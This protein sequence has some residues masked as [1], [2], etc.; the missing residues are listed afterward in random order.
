MSNPRPAEPSEFVP[1]DY[2][3][4]VESGELFTKGAPLEVDLGTGDGSFLLQ[5]AARHPERNFL[6]VE[7]FL[8]RVRKVCRRARDLKLINLRVLR[9]EA[10]YTVEWLLPQS[11]VSRLHLLFP[12]PWPK[13]K[14]HKRRL[15]QPEFLAA[16]HKL[17]VP[18]GEFLFK[19]DHDEY[20]EWARDNLENFE[21]FQLVDW[22]EGEF[23]YPPTDFEE[24]WRAEG[25]VVHRLRAVSTV[26]G[27]G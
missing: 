20:F 27:K 10:R 25:R 16:L 22:P 19:T 13:A 5:M 3:R 6:G 12:D 1:T 4:R 15:L 14:H 7:R 21:P 18:S 9:L 26:D 23:F 2:F 24:Q 8:G 17:L 11:S